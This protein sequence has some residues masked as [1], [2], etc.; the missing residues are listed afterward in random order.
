MYHVY[1]RYKT[2]LFPSLLRKPSLDPYDKAKIAELL[3]K[4][5]N[6][7]IRR[8]SGLTEKARLLKDHTLLRQYGGWSAT[9][10]MHEKYVH[11]FNNESNESLLEAYGLINRNK[12]ETDKLKPRLCLHCNEQNKIDSKFCSNPRCR[13]VLTIDGYISV[14]EENR[15]SQTKIESLSNEIQSMKGML[16]E[17][18]LTIKRQ[19]DDQ[20]STLGAWKDEIE[21][22][23]LFGDRYSLTYRDRKEDNEIQRELIEIINH[24]LKKVELESSEY[25]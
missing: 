4:P 10:N 9:S 19:M 25:Y 24:R 15:Q 18:V 17:Y 16:K 20:Q 6:P 12:Q 8:H 5:W 23:L 14:T 7:Y 11:Y 21:H 1:E 13:T 2:Q 3:K 22:R